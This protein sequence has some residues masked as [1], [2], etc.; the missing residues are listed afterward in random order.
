VSLLAALAPNSSATTIIRDFIS[1]GSMFPT[2]GIT[3]TGAPSNAVGAGDLVTIFN[4]AADLWES[5]LLDSH[6]LTLHFGWVSLGMAGQLTS[7]NVLSSGGS[8][9]REL[10]A[11]IGFDSSAAPVFY[12]DPTPMVHTEYTTFT[13]TSA[14]L[15]G[16]S[17][18][19]G[20][21]FTGATGLAV[22]AI[23][24]F[25]VALREIGHALGLSSANAAFNAGNGDMDVDVTAPRP[26]PGSEIPTVTQAH[27]DLIN[28]LM[29]P[30]IAP[31]VRK[32]PS[33]A[34]I[35]A[36]AQISQ[37]ETI[38]LNPTLSQ[39]PEPGTLLLLS[40]GLIGLALLRKRRAS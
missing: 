22:G 14:D 17:M 18:N 13:T 11:N 1:S 24:L 21:V 20:R 3:A 25:T 30:T 9:Y 6:T 29:F 8:P 12:L 33:A 39:V 4:A 31:G 37:F 40:G 34:D 26:F 5:A 35:L 23:D 16:G 38:N 10:E 27:L 28:A 36:N 15:G 19:V 2:T 32:L 7:H